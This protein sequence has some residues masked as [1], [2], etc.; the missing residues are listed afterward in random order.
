M[1]V[2]SACL[3]TVLH[4]FVMPA[5][6]VK[7]GTYL[8]CPNNTCNLFWGKKMCIF[9]TA[10]LNKFLCALRKIKMIQKL[11]GFHIGWIWIVNSDS[12]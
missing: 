12:F 8:S 7:W 3:D 6:K 1:N 2:Y 10:H 11:F 4:A 9:S 5:K